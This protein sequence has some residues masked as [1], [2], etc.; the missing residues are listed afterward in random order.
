MKLGIE[1]RG[2]AT[3]EANMPASDVPLR[4]LGVVRDNAVGHKIVVRGPT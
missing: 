2:R 1:I 4:D 3:N